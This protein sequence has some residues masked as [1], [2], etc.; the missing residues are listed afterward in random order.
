MDDLLLLYSYSYSHF[1]SSFYF[2]SYSYSCS[3]SHCC[4]CCCCCCWCCDKG[5]CWT[6][7][8]R[9]WLWQLSDVRGSARTHNGNAD[10]AMVGIDVDLLL[11]AGTFTTI[12][13]TTWRSYRKRQQ[14]RWLWKQSNMRSSP[15]APKAK[16]TFTLMNIDIWSCC[17]AQ[18]VMTKPRLL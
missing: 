8:Q 15:A 6:P 14:R 10:N 13:T 3:Y 1:W 7:Q 18:I 4:W 16:L 2:Y 9:R 12:S 11:V 17:K 5:S